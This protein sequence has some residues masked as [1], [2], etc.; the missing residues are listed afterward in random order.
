MSRQEI[1]PAKA[2]SESISGSKRS[3]LIQTCASCGRTMNLGEG[4]TLFGDKWFHGL[5]W[6]IEAER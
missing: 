3:F 6:T 5:C 1:E 2:V 4:D